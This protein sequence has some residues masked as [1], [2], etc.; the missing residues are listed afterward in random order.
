[1]DDGGGK[2]RDESSAEA[3]ALQLNN[4]ED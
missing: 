2:K 1:V 4:C 3:T